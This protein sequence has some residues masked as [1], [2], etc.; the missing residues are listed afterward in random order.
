M[1]GATIKVPDFRRIDEAASKID[2]AMDASRA[3]GAALVE[4]PQP[5]PAELLPVEPFPLKALPD[6]L[7]PWVADVA[8]R[9]Q[10]PPD[11]VAVPMLVGAAM[12][13]A[14]KVRIK[15]QARTDWT[16]RAN[17]WALIVG[18]PGAMKS[19]AMMQALAPLERMEARAAAEHSK[20]M[21]AFKLELLAHELR[22]GAGEKAAKAELSKNKNADIRGHLSGDEPQAP[23]WP[24]YLVNDLT[25]EKLGVLLS[26]NPDGVLSVRDEMRGLFLHLAREEQAPARAFYLQAWSGGR[27][28]FDRVQ[29][30]TTTIE[31]ARLSMI[32]CIQPGPLSALVQQARRG[33]ADDGML[34]RF[35]VAW[36][37]SAGD[38]REVDRFPDSEAKRGAWSVFSRLD[39][40]D[41]AGILAQQDSDMDGNPEGLP[42]LRFADDAREAFSEW[43][44]DLERKLRTT[45]AEGLEGALSKFRHHVP[46]MA[47]ALHVIDG[48]AGPVALAPT[49]R[50]LALSEYFESHARRLHGSNR[51]VAVRAA[52]AL[53]SRAQ[54]SALPD[55][56]T[57][58][59]VYI[60][61]WAGREGRGQ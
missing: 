9:I 30:G 14:R 54:A 22:A 10:C 15:C 12:L 49:L 41:A 29:R 34:D 6:A 21:E 24:R 7:R 36:P 33:A 52:R 42:F 3:G 4:A 25:Y 8:E 37:D 61:D 48:G 31:D 20:D 2:A 45:E 32:G 28:T 27:Y 19:P 59:E 5:L 11:F 58:R 57:A 23:T 60:R 53:L 13:V 40:L 35:L 39:T 46:A 55:P 17:L 50:A 38:W 26:E 1:S 43:H 47:L 56:F 18:R 16:E 44:H 51:R